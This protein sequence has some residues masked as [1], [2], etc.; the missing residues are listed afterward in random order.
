MI[1]SSLI[2]NSCGGLRLS[3]LRIET[4]PPS[5]LCFRDALDS[6]DGLLLKRFQSLGLS[7]S[8]STGRASGFLWRSAPH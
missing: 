7:S 3:T 2:P 1:A 5:L 6:A 8:R 4:L